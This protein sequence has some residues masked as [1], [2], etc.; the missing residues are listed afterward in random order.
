MRFRIKAN[1]KQLYLLSFD[2]SYKIEHLE[3][4]INVQLLVCFV[5][6]AKKREIFSA[7]AKL[8]LTKCWLPA[9]T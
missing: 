8:A 3:T 5:S 6:N 7:T 9:N 1:E 4:I 2:D